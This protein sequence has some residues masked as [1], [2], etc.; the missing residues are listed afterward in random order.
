VV[1]RFES[2]AEELGI[3]DPQDLINWSLTILEKLRALHKRGYEIMAVDPTD[4]TAIRITG[5]FDVE[6]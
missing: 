5:V 4:K 1:S 2:L 6:D 3:E